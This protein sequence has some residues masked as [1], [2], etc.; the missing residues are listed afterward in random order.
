M[1]WFVFYLSTPSCAREI[2]GAFYE[3]K[4]TIND[5]MYIHIVIKS[6]VVGICIYTQIYMYLLKENTSLTQTC[7][8]MLRLTF[9]E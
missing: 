4:D 5:Y 6:T 3:D 8:N 1:F 7:A 9:P 2:E